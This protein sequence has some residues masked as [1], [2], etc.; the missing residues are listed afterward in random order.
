MRLVPS[1]WSPIVCAAL[2]LGV[3]PRAAADTVN[4]IVLGLRSVEGD[5][6]VA[7]ALTDALRDAAHGVT[8]WKL[9][10]RSVSMAQM[11]LA[12]GCD[13]IDAS[14]LNEIAKGLIADRVVYGTVRRTSARETYDYQVSLSV[15]DAATGT[16]GS[17]ETTTVPSAEARD[18]QALRPRAVVLMQHVSG[19]KGGVGLL[20]IRVD[21]VT[22]DVRLDGEMVGQTRDH[23]LLLDGVPPGL[24]QLDIDA[25]GYPTR[26]VRIEVSSREQTNVS[27]AMAGE[28][29]E[30]QAAGGA[31][32]GAQAMDDE[33]LAGP[34]KGG[35]LRW[36]GYT[37]IG[38][39]GASILG[40]AASMLVVN[41]IN[42][43]ATYQKYSSALPAS[44]DDL[45][46]EAESGNAHGMT[47]KELDDVVS[48]CGTG[49]TFEVLQYVFL[50]TALVGGGVGAYILLTDKERGAQAHAGGPGLALTPTLSTRSALLT[51][52][53]TF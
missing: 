27:V 39:G 43:D 26:S 9:I 36:L 13:D 24:H 10:D 49:S 46:V 53:L 28:L 1:L 4:V 5:D 51:A 37:L 44:I 32:T 45:C 12:Y 35:S 22:A 18:A 20:E 47:A 34:R 41:N 2:L 48:M 23:V 50:G 52:K 21:V 14:C 11:S 33:A 29:V 15:F 31:G 16:I 8:D 25:A 30:P 42:E 40:L 3:V 6:D 38:V 19:N 7:N 17:N